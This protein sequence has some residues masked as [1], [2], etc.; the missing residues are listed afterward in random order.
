MSSGLG[1]VN[2]RLVWCG[3]NESKEKLSTIRD[4]LFEDKLVISRKVDI[5]LRTES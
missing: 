2:D 3:A 4:N 5:V 1:E